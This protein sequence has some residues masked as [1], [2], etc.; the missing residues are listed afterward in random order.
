MNVL[1]SK[2][3]HKSTTICNYFLG[4]FPNVAYLLIRLYNLHMT[5]QE[6]IQL[7]GSQSELARLLKISR[8]AVSMWKNVPELRMRQLKDLR[9]EWFVV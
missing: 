3:N 4:V 9:P 2:L 8:A 1:L 5:K 7:A 6:L